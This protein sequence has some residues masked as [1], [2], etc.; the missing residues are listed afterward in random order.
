MGVIMLGGVI[1]MNIKGTPLPRAIALAM[2]LFSFSVFF[3]DHFSEE[4][5]DIYHKEIVK[6]LKIIK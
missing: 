2:M 3:L 4:R 1:L 5:A 6:A